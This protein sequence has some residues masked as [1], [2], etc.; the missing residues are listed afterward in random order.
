MWHWRCSCSVAAVRFGKG[1]SIRWDMKLTAQSDS[2]NDCARA[3]CE[4]QSNAKQTSSGFHAIILMVVDLTSASRSNGELRQQ[5]Q[6]SDAGYV[7]VILVLGHQEVNSLWPH[8]VGKS[9]AR[10]STLGVPEL[11]GLS[12]A[13]L[14]SRGHH[15]RLWRGH[16]GGPW[17][18]PNT[19]LPFQAHK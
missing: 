13:V 11:S 7:P 2:S 4:M 19:R 18:N 9:V 14:V 12:K 15:S 1:R 10:Y 17:D 3:V 5:G 16:Q 6:R 8:L